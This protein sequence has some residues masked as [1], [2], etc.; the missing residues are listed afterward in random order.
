[1]RRD[2]HPP[3]RGDLSQRER[4]G[5]ALRAGWVPAFAEVAARRGLVSSP[6]QGGGLGSLSPSGRRAWFPLPVRERVRVRVVPFIVAAIASPTHKETV[7]AVRRRGVV[8]DGAQRAPSGG[9]VGADWIPAYAG[10]TALGRFPF[11]R[12]WV[13]LPVGSRFRGNDVAPGIWGRRGAVAPRLVA[14]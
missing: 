14:P 8:G 3:L 6:R 2:P 9:A 1:M 4:L 5:H 11:S 13:A 10:M 12:A 7:A